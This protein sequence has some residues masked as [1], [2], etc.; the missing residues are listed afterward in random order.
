MGAFSGV[1]V[2]RDFL[3]TDPE[4]INPATI[5]QHTDSNSTSADKMADQIKRRNAIN[6]KKQEIQRK[7]HERAEWA[8]Q[9][10]CTDY[11]PRACDSQA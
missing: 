9:V 5:Q 2:R 1:T 4:H 3:N 11:I 7:E 8:D 10:S 6:A